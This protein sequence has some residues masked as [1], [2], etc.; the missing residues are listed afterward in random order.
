M[1]EE[2][3][4]RNRKTIPLP[5]MTSV[6][7]YLEMLLQEIRRRAPV[8]PPPIPTSLPIYEE[9]P[10]KKIKIQKAIREGYGC[11]YCGGEVNTLT[12]RCTNCGAKIY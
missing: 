3:E 4:K 1:S 6:P 7:I 9:L 12:G 2:E 8:T 5:P 10:L 11:P